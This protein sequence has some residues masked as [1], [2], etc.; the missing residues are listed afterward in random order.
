MISGEHVNIFKTVFR[1][2]NDVFAIR[3][4]KENRS[5]YMPAYFFDPYR[6]RTHRIKGGTFQNFSDK[7]YLPLTDEQIKKHLNGEQLIGIYPLLQDNTSWFIAV[8]FDEGNWIGECQIVL[9]VCKEKNI[10]AYLERSRSGN[11]GHVW[12]FFK[13]P[14]ASLLTRKVVFALL[15][16]ANIISQFDRDSSFDRLFPNQDFHSGK[17]L[18]NLIALPLYKNSLQQ[19]NSCFIDVNT[20]KPFNDQWQFLKD[21][22]RVS[23]AKFDDLFNKID[24]VEIGKQTQQVASSKLTI[25]LDNQI[26]IS[27]NTIPIALTNFLKEELNFANTEFFVKKKSGRNTFGTKQYFKFIEETINFV[28]L[29]KGFIGRVIRFCKQKSIEYDFIDERKKHVTVDYLFNVQLRPYQTATIEASFKKDIGIIVAPPG[30]GKTVIGLKIIAEKKQPALIVVHRKEL[31]NQWIER[32]EAFLNIPKNEIGKIERG[33][34]KIGKKITIATIQSL[35]KEIEKMGSK[36]FC[37]AFGVILVDECHHIPAATY[38]NT[39]SKFNSFYLYGLTATPFRKYNE[40]KVIFIHLGEI[41]SE[42]KPIDT[43]NKVNPK[44]VI[45]TT[46]FNVPFNSRTDKFETLSKILVHDSSRNQL[47]LK[48]IDTELKTGRKAVIITE[49]KEHIDSLYQYLKQ[50]YEVVTLSGEDSGGNLKTKWKILRDGNYQALITTGQ[51]FGEG[52]DLQNVN[53]LFLVYPFSFEGKLIQYI[54]R[55]Q[56]S[57][58][59]PTIY[60]YRDIEIDY[61]NKLFLKR[62]AYYRKLQSQITLFDDAVEDGAVKEKDIVLINKELKIPIDIL[63]FRY[64]SIAFSYPLTEVNSSLEFEIE[65]NEM[66]PE[67]EVLKPSFIKTLH[68]KTILVNISVE[69]KGNELLSQLATSKDLDKI[70]KELIDGVRFR[71][72]DKKFL[73]RLSRNLSNQENPVYYDASELNSL[74]DSGEELLKDILKQKQFKHYYQLR[75]LAEHHA[76]DILKI[77]FILH[78]FSF[79]F[80]LCG[81]EQMH[82]ILE[83][84]DTEEATYLWHR[85]KESYSILEWL[86]EIDRQLNIIHKEGRQVFLETK[87]EKF[88]RILHDYSDSRKGF[89]IWKNLLEEQIA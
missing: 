71:F 55:V 38:R 29:P 6:F 47:I 87:P 67:F 3:W 60:D 28:I 20:W 30:S 57:D 24:S 11:G 13:E 66:R 2:R 39:L 84:L 12:I 58:T 76:R 51:F 68:S 65:N 79:V 33:K 31:A 32:I 8:D 45:R 53:C 49:R 85:E 82:I 61:L 81:E 83:T 40:G 21:I 34:V 10:P 7:T 50:S 72:V 16:E 23:K 69:Y 46:S 5:G 17:G 35:T 88:S 59:T 27:R 48:D 18:G 74:Y 75:Y 26:Q 80:L 70:N 56:R 89:I 64:G 25:T 1:G 9:K 44:I 15:L 77:R 73:S 4:E 22:E 36:N 43:G 86:N 41:I 14:L 42:I 54:G 62:N 37:D 52:T 19:G 63:E 78:P